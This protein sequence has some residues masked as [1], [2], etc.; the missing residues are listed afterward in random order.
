MEVWAD[1][2]IYIV[3][4]L[5]DGL[6]YEIPKISLWVDMKGLH[7]LLP[8]GIEY[9]VHNFKNYWETFQQIFK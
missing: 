2:L 1:L 7:S 6:K 3:H 5:F 9:L 4:V 8:E